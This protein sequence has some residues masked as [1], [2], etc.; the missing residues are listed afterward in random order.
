MVL[1]FQTLYVV[2]MLFL[3]VSIYPSCAFC[4]EGAAQ[5]YFR[6]GDGGQKHDGF[7]GG[8]VT[9]PFPAPWVAKSEDQNH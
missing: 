7:K 1:N 4:I 5:I 9:Q 6:G 8:I 3:S 2:G